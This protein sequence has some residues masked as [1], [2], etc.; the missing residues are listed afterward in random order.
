[1]T[2]WRLCSSQCSLS[3]FVLTICMAGCGRSEQ[4]PSVPVNSGAVS[5]TSGGVLEIETE[6]AAPSVP[7]QPAPVQ[8]PATVT[9]ATVADVGSTTDPALLEVVP[10]QSADVTMTYEE[11]NAIRSDHPNLESNREKYQDKWIAF[12]GF[13]Y[14]I[15][16]N[17]IHI[18][19]YNLG[20]EYVSNVFGP[21]FAVHTN[22]RRPW[23]ILPVW[24]RVTLIAQAD[25]HGDSQRPVRL[26]NATWKI[27]EVPPAAP[28]YDV[29]SFLDQAR[30]D[31]KGFPGE[32]LFA[33]HRSSV[34]VSGKLVKAYWFRRN[35][36]E[37][38]LSN[39]SGDQQVSFNI[40][41]D[42]VAEV[43]KL[44]PGEECQFLVNCNF[45]ASDPAPPMS[46]HEFDAY[47]MNPVRRVP[48]AS[49]SRLQT[50]EVRDDRENGSTDSIDLSSDGNRLLVVRVAHG[51]DS[52]RFSVDLWDTRDGSKIADL[53]REGK[54][55]TDGKI[56]AGGQ[57][58]LLMESRDG[59]NEILRVNVESR[60]IIESWPGVLTDGLS[61]DRSRLASHDDSGI[62]IREIKTGQET[63]I[64]E[65]GLSGV[66]AIAISPD[67]ELVAVADYNGL[68]VKVWNLATGLLVK[69]LESKPN[70]EASS[71]RLAFDMQGTRLAVVH[72]GTLNIFDTKTF[73][74]VLER[75]GDAYKYSEAVGFSGDFQK[76]VTSGSDQIS[77]YDITTG[78]LDVFFD[79]K[80]MAIDPAGTTI[81]TDLNDGVFRFLPISVWKQ[82]TY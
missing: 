55:L 49:D 9:S 71:V 7:M 64:P 72:Y 19:G 4:P 70:S 37:V 74:K 52:S 45:N 47:L 46:E 67:N 40:F 33:Y 31:P 23:L 44:Q 29:T 73:E 58:V 18:G 3:I 78:E 5:S 26:R 42:R 60:E 34:I 15:E 75:S 25:F 30:K 66:Q 36:G 16:A 69:E 65:H 21:G 51:T 59:P 68:K 35:N 8:T 11:W 17:A 14:K 10:T 48:A 13:V 20:P 1:M 81:V 39:Q 38:I 41:G 82:F 54:V 53:S 80:S 57:E 32:S 6:P 76:I 12:D 61:P 56:L 27:K 2:I 62:T 24:S 43:M 50:R 22:I 28:T 63:R 79:G 77:C